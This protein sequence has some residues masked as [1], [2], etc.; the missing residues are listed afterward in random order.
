MAT[1]ISARKLGELIATVDHGLGMYARILSES[2]IALGVDPWNPK[3][4]ID[5]TKETVETRGSLGAI[6]SVEQPSSSITNGT[7][8]IDLRLS[9]R[10]RRRG[11]YWYELDGKRVEC[12]SLKDLLASALGAL[13]DTRPGTLDRLTRVKPRSKRIVAN[14]ACDLFEDPHL[15]EK[16]AHPLRD[17]WWYGS[18]NSSQE[19]LEWLKRAALAAGLAFGKDFKVSMMG[20][21]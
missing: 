20:D 17:G 4:I 6:S 18:N 19:T 2:A 14:S 8:S 9:K 16:F 11:V 5:L 10:G 3:Y 1:V 21:R 13:E 12:V 7:S 15:T